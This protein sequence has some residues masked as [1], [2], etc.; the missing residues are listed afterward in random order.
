MKSG[1][2]G[3]EVC[4]CLDERVVSRWD[5]YEKKAM[6]WAREYREQQCKA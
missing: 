3:L 5:E 1:A 6:G 2:Q 4:E